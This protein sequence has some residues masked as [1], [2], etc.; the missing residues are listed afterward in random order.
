M[1]RA[2][3]LT[4]DFGDRDPY[5]GIM[6]GVIL[7]INPEALL[8]DLCHQVTPHGVAEAAF[9]VGISHR[10]FPPGTIHLVVADP[11]V[12]SQR[13][14]I[15]LAT[16]G[17]FFVAPDNGVLSYVVYEAERDSGARGQSQP[18]PGPVALLAPLKAVAIT[19]PRYWLSSVSATFHGRDILA[20]VAAHLSLGTPLE[21]FGEEVNSVLCLPPPRPQPH[22]DGA[23]LGHVLHVDSFGNLITDIR[24]EHL[25]GG[26]LHLE[27]AGRSIQGLSPYY[28]AGEGLMAVV[29]SSGYVEVAVQQGSAACLLG[30]G[31][32]EP[33]RVIPD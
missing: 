31:R 28:A 8:I 12:G 21:A 13:R 4:S 1:G 22:P 20:P 19:N 3:T 26:P 2:I 23:L 15:V 29:G 6:K 5:V 27:V 7:G 25:P 16:S 10:Y 11:G 17:A 9:I 32:G 33:V 24:Q 18:G 14:S 30:V